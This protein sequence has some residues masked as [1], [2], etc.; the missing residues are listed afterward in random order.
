MSLSSATYLQWNIDEASWVE[1]LSSVNASLP[2][3]LDDRYLH[4]QLDILSRVVLVSSRKFTIYF[5]VLDEFMLSG[6]PH[7]EPVQPKISLADGAHWYAPLL[8]GR[9]IR[10]I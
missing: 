2:S 4:E 3:L 1:L 8:D 6:Y 9:I 5:K 10:S 7:Q